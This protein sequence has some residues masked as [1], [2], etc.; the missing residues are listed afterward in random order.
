MYILR[1]ELKEVTLSL[2]V[3]DRRRI[4]KELTIFGHN[5]VAPFNSKSEFLMTLLL[6][7]NHI[8][9]ED[10][11]LLR[12]E[13]FSRNPNMSAFQITSPRGFGERWTREHLVAIDHRF[14][15]PTKEQ[16]Y[17]YNGNYNY[18]VDGRI[19]VEVCSS[20]AVQSNKD[21]PLHLKALRSRSKKP[22]DMNLQQ[23]KP[24]CC[25]VIVI[26]G[27]WLDVVRYWV[28]SSQEIASNQYYCKTQHRGNKGE[29]QIHIKH[30][31]INYFKC[32]ESSP[33]HLIR[34]IR[35]AA[36]RTLLD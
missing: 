10:V 22:F 3:N 6:G 17:R 32:N 34:D 7:F 13:Y 36:K 21:S 19:R 30:N 33:V 35:R 11:L 18:L 12:S 26:I 14:V 2:P 4:R 27:V 20:R 31:N 16:D 23:I 25:D 9:I 5:S 28:F 29:G 8:S 15:V 24:S 1:K